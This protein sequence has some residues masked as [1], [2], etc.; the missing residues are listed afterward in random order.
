MQPSSAKHPPTRAQRS[1]KR[2]SRERQRRPQRR[3]REHPSALRP[4]AR[5]PA[6][7]GLMGR[8]TR[9]PAVRSQRLGRVATGC[10]GGCNRA[11]QRPA[12]LRTR[13]ALLRAERRANLPS[14]LAALGGLVRR[15]QSVRE[16]AHS[17]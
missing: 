1:A 13:L 4:P 6:I 17:T 7:C 14:F 16:R 12:A 11:V 5:P 9:R 3:Y 2:T 15:L 8:T 10:A